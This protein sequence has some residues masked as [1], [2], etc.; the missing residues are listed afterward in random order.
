MQKMGEAKSLAS[1]VAMKLVRFY[2]LFISPFFPPTCR[3]EPTCSQY[4]LIAF[5]RYG[6]KKGLV[7]T[8]KRLSKCR[9][10]GP[11]GYDPVP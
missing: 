2:Q 11:H 6:F 10:G 5:E 4:S 1:F 8:L 3:F 9:P 7:L